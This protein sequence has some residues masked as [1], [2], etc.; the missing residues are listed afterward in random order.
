MAI[1]KA[2]L[3]SQIADDLADQGT[4]A[5]TAAGFLER[6][7]FMAMGDVFRAPKIFS[8]LTKQSS[9]SS[10]SGTVEYS[11]PSDFAGLVPEKNL[12]KFYAYDVYAVPPSI[13]DGDMGRRYPIVYNE[14]T[15]TIR[16]FSD[17]GTGTRTFT[18]KKALTEVDDVEDW[19]TT[20]AEA[21]IHQEWLQNFLTIRTM[22]YA[23]NPTED[24]AKQAQRQ[25]DLSEAIMTRVLA[26]LSRTQSR[27]DT[28]TTRDVNG[29]PYFY[30]FQGREE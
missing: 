24:F 8:F 10:V 5:T 29:N 20:A 16:F 19:L 25:W 7:L 22:F 21:Q 26:N 9:I 4:F 28:R 11:V 14:V 6:K 13:S 2:T 15:R 30:S 18:Y 27:P 1:V 17:P 3:L 12:N 23:L